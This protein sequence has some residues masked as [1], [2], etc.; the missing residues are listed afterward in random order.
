MPKE[1]SRNQ[2]VGE[3]IQ[4][5]LA[6]IICREVSMPGLGMLTVA[7]V[8]VSP[9]LKFAKVYITLLG[10]VFTPNQVMQHLNEIAGRLRHHLS[11]RLT[12]R[13]TPRLQFVHDTS[14][15][16]GVKLSALIDSVAPPPLEN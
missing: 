12:I 10:G 5:E 3:L 4:R 13:T 8:K 16:Y 6:D 7:A 15:E 2:R 11:Q 14:I 9:D 1:F